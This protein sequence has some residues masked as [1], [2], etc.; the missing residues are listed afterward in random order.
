[1]EVAGPSRARDLAREA[2]TAAG[3]LTPRPGPS[4][5]WLAILDAKSGSLRLRASLRI[6]DSLSWLREHLE[7]EARLV[8]LEIDHAGRNENEGLAVRGVNGQP[9]PGWL[10]S[11]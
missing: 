2:L 4:I 3:S 9:S 8:T 5:L 10:E 1:M 7:F 6:L 11:D